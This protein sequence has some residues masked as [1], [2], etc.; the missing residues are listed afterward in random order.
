MTAP[1]TSPPRTL[2]EA[3][4]PHVVDLAVRVPVV[5]E[6]AGGLAVGR[7]GPPCGGRRAGRTDPWPPPTNAI[8]APC[9]IRNLLII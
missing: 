1:G 6:G 2:A 4:H 3:G 7:L 5:E 9:A 8:R